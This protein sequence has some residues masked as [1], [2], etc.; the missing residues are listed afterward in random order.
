MVD[1]VHNSRTWICLPPRTH[2]TTAC[3]PVL[4]TNVVLEPQS[5]QADFP[6]H[7]S[8]KHKF[9]FVLPNLVACGK[10]AAKPGYRRRFVRFSV[11]AGLYDVSHF[12]QPFSE[13]LEISGNV[14]SADILCCSTAPRTRNSTPLAKKID[15]SNRDDYRPITLTSCFSKNLDLRFA[16]RTRPIPVTVDAFETRRPETS[17]KVTT[18]LRFATRTRPIPVTVDTF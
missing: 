16:T 18:V 3:A 8:R 9:I 14:S 10:L 5:N 6:Q 4:T 13:L 15:S 1:L 12:T 2:A 11:A 7:G 17:P